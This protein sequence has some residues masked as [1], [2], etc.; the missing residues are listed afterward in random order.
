M[1]S[2]AFFI[3]AAI[4]LM[5]HLMTSPVAAQS[6]RDVTENLISDRVATLLTKSEPKKTASNDKK[7]D[8]SREIAQTTQPTPTTQPQITTLPTVQPTVTATVLP[9]VQPTR[10]PVATATPTPVI[11]V[12]T[13]SARLKAPTPTR[14]PA[15][16]LAADVNKPITYMLSLLI[17][18]LF[19]V[20]LATN[21]W[22]HK[23]VKKGIVATGLNKI[24]KKKT[25]PPAPPVIVEAPTKPARRRRTSRK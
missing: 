11:A 10:V 5:I 12:A 4:Y 1:K 8:N 16:F 18:V 23:M 20:F 21:K 17:V 14:I 2:R 15:K 25:L 6:L 3:V 9:T 24:V 7:T 22:L 19:I 13:S